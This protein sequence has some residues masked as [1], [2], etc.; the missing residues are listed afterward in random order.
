MIAQRLR[1][2][3]LNNPLGIDFSSPRLFW[4]VSGGKKQTAYQIQAR[5][6][7]GIFWDSGK[8]PSSF[9][10]GLPWQGPSVNSRTLVFW[11]V[12]LWDEMDT[13]G[14]WSEEARFETGLLQPDDWK[15][16]WIT[17]SYSPHRRKRYPVDYFKKSFSVDKSVKNARLYVTACGVYTAAVNGVS[18]GNFILAPGFTDYHKRIYYQTYDVTPLL[19]PGQNTLSLS[20]ADGW[21]RGSL[22]A[23]GVTGVYGKQTKLLLQLEITYMDDSQLM[24]CSD[25][26]F[27]WSNDGPLL[28]AD[29]KDGEIIDARKTP[30]YAGKA[31]IT[32]YPITPTAS[33]SLSV[34]EKERFQP[35]L[36][37][38]PSG[39][40][41]LDFEQNLAGYI[42][43]S[44]QAKAG[45]RLLIQLGETLKAGELDMANIQL[46]ANTSKA[47][48]L[49]RISYICKEGLNTYKTTF[50]IFGFRYAS[51]EAD[52]P[53][54]AEDFTS[55]ALY[56]D[57]PQTGHFSCSNPLINRFVENTL[58]S[59]KSNFLDIP[60]DCPTRERAPWTGDVQ[61]FCKTGSYLME[62]APF[63]RKW[64]YDLQDRQNRNGKIP[65]HAPDVR[66]NEY[67]PGIDFI[68]RMDGC[69]G[70]ADVAVLLPWRMFRMY[71]DR[72][73]LEAF[74]PMM[75]S[76][77]QFQ[78]SRTGK[79]GLFGKPF[80]SPDKTYI[81]NVGQAF[82]EW[83]EPPEV[84]QQSVLQDF[85]APHP[86]EATA[87]LSYICGIMQKVAKLTGHLE[88]LPLYEEYHN[89]CKMAYNHQFVHQGHIDTSRQSKLVRPLAFNLLEDE[90]KA[91]VLSRLVTSIKA[92]NYKV[93][94]GFLSTPL[95]LPTLTR[96]GQLDTAYKMMENEASP[97]WLAEVKAGATTVWENWD[98]TASNNHYSPG[99]VCEWLFESVCGIRIL[100]EN[101]FS[102]APLPGGNI[103]E[104]SFVYDSIYG[105]VSSSWKKLPDGIQFMF[106]VP[107]GCEAHISLPGGS[108]YDV[109]AGYYQYFERQESQ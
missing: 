31:T 4:Q 17:G 47:T 67:L 89:G 95:L 24:I 108:V 32:S 56:S 70:W 64:L 97:G 44:I 78:I 52:F 62:T 50:A 36:S 33:N 51:L 28:F 104:A 80:P 60:T 90:T 77:I 22:G 13:P 34:V 92:R 12:R 103:K 53:V 91:N 94:T 11:K 81:S 43:F 98:G 41:L 3:Y 16:S 9:M 49:Q 6:S 2:E 7:Q 5:T 109:P 27:S 107:D 48:P 18:A 99:S 72:T 23:L 86:E 19:Q 74:Y 8:I 83:L 76:H 10:A 96:Y 58:W 61:I 57:M 59:M 102:L 30:S 39:K 65:C 15:A 21:F 82:G 69:C 1:T 54:R 66:N 20:L 38:T 71:Q 46:R 106:L 42:S 29:L 87:Y 100:A 105:S 25:D 63:F 88:D 101:E 75:K 37:R 93:G 79:T 73:F 26:S 35:V 84:Y 45:Q 55:I 85:M 14:L 40:I 68:K